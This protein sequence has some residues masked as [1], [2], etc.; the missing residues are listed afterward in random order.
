M[1]LNSRNNVCQSYVVVPIVRHGSQSRDIQSCNWP[2]VNTAK[3]YV[4]MYPLFR[5]P[6]KKWSTAH[7]RQVLKRAAIQS[8][9]C[10]HLVTC[11]AH[12]QKSGYTS[13][14]SVYVSTLSMGVKV[15]QII[16]SKY[17][18]KRISCSCLTF[19]ASSACV[20]SYFFHPC[21]STQVKQWYWLNL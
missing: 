5:W 10:M 13:Y 3:A 9:S 12:T 8:C 1:F 21:W 17:S 4:F 15:S 19:P 2:V 14:N 18:F 16:N 20:L 7:A 6:G 11:R